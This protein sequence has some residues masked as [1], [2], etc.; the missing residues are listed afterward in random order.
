M[1]SFSKK[2]IRNGPRRVKHQESWKTNEKERL[3]FGFNW[4]YDDHLIKN[5]HEYFTKCGVSQTSITPEIKY[6]AEAYFTRHELSKG[7]KS[8]PKR[9][10]N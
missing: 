8:F 5:G 4:V 2:T 3:F 1:K 10:M 9:K 7:L 6:F